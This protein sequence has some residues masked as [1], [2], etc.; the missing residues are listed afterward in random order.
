M[1]NKVNLKKKNIKN[2]NIFVNQ[3]GIWGIIWFCLDQPAPPEMERVSTLTCLIGFIYSLQCFV[4]V[5]FK[6]IIRCSHFKTKTCIY[7]TRLMIQKPLWISK[8]NSRFNPLF[9]PSQL[10]LMLFVQLATCL[11]SELW[12]YTSVLWIQFYFIHS[13]LGAEIIGL[14][15]N[16]TSNW[17]ERHSLFKTTLIKD[18]PRFPPRMG[19]FPTPPLISGRS[20]HFECMCGYYSWPFRTWGLLAMFQSPAFITGIEVLGNETIGKGVLMEMQSNGIF[21]KKMF[22]FFFFRGRKKKRCSSVNKMRN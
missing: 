14:Q 4:D 10:K 2:K 19:K 15:T 16:E 22:L 11:K 21:L 1:Q 13:D 18:P 20:L 7:F 12:D 3:W 9:A 8:K 6:H 17:D 5:S